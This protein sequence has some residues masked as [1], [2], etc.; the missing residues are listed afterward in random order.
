MDFCPLSLLPACRQ[1][2]AAITW[3]GTVLRELLHPS[4][5]RDAQH[6]DE[7]TIARA[8]P[9][10]A[11]FCGAG[12]KERKQPFAVAQPCYQQRLRALGLVQL[13]TGKS[14]EFAVPGEEVTNAFA[15]LVNAPATAH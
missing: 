13:Q 7:S 12:A 5:A 3:A 11:G 14:I 10:V 9:N 2:Q 1:R 4:P 15:S 6:R 8:A